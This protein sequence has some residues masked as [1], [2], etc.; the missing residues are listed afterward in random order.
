MSLEIQH[1]TRE[2]SAFQSHNQIYLL[3]QNDKKCFVKKNLHLFFGRTFEY[4][5]QSKN[6]INFE[7]IIFKI[8]FVHQEKHTFCCKKAKQGRF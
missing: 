3:L 8:V 2:H 4:F 6:K 5:S 7:T 1:D